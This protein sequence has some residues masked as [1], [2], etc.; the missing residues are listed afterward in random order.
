MDLCFDVAA[1]GGVSA[2]AEW[3]S[4]A[5]Y[6]VEAAQSTLATLMCYVVKSMNIAPHWCG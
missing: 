1:A 6:G 2:P 4:L 3:Q 5:L